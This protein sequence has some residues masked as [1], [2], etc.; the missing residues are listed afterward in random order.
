M[1][2]QLFGAHAFYVWSALAA[3]AAGIA[4]ELWALRR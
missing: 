2:I 4:V 3:V 1:N